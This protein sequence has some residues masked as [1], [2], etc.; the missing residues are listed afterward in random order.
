MQTFLHWL[1]TL[2]TTLPTAP[3]LINLCDDRVNFALVLTLSL[4]RKTPCLLPPDRLEQTHADLLAAYPGAIRITDDDVAAACG[5]ETASA[6]ATTTHRLIPWRPLVPAATTAAIAFAPGTHEPLAH[7]KTWGALTFTAR[8]LARR[9]DLTT[10]T[11]LIPTVPPQ[12]MYGLEMSIMLP[13]YAG[14]PTSSQRPLFPADI[15]TLLE[16]T[17]GRKVLVS[18]PIHLAAIASTKGSWP[19]TDAVISSTSPLSSAL[20]ERIERQLTTRVMEVYGT[21]ETGSLATRRTLDGPDWFWLDGISAKKR[22][23]GRVIVCG[24]HLDI[25]AVL[26]D[27]IFLSPRGLRLLGPPRDLIK[28]AG[29]RASLSALNRHLESIPGVKAGSFILAADPTDT[30]SRLSAV[31]VAPGRSRGDILNGLKG[32]IDP[33]FLPR[34]I[35][36]VAALPKD[37]AGE[38]CQATLAALATGQQPKAASR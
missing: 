27:H 12:H 32:R 24:E 38:P 3:Y 37:S 13:L 11:T 35:I 34:R 21:T 30:F 18:T 2:S 19:Q 31:V 23:D 17:P 33:L 6:G 22:R 36:L 8:T 16:R 29:K 15:R 25:D 26:L 28:V 10:D 1:D 4:L 14:I 7:T 20:A 9:L 5:P